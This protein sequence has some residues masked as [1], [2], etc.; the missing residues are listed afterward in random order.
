[1]MR[2][3]PYKRKSIRLGCGI[4]SLA[5]ILPVCVFTIWFFNMMSARHERREQNCATAVAKPILDTVVNDLCERK[6]IPTSLGECG[7]DS[8]QTQDVMTIVTSHV[9]ANTSTY[10][11]V[12]SIFGTYETYCELRLQDRATFRCTYNIGYWPNIF[13]FYST[14]TEIVT[15]ITSTSCIGGS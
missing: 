7:N 4:V 1:M 13:I 15:N 11:E 3:K 5:I 10:S 8:F 2:F 9:Y 6:L 12:T 14:K